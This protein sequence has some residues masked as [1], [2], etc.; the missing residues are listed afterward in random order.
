MAKE[1][2]D[3]YLDKTDDYKEVHHDIVRALETIYDEA[4][5]QDDTEETRE[6]L[7]HERLLASA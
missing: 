2:K 6:I 4:V 5:Y 1:Q 3:V 7:M